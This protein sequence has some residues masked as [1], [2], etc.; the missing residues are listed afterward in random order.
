MIPV[1]PKQ[2]QKNKNIL[3]EAEHTGQLTRRK[4]PLL[5]S[6]DGA[7]RTNQLLR[8]GAMKPKDAL[9]T[10][11]APEGT[12]RRNTA[13]GLKNSENN[14][15]SQ[16]KLYRLNHGSI[17]TVFGANWQHS[18][19]PQTR[20]TNQPLAFVKARAGSTQRKM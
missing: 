9:R 19:T 2:L 7:Q 11:E 20:C 5:K 10:V 16:R 12:G 3:R 13:Q 4:I 6:R 8:R 1:L 14:R 18:R 15:K 17:C